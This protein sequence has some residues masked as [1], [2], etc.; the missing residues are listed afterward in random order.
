V[1][2][3]LLDPTNVADRENRRNRRK[4]NVK[5]GWIKS[6]YIVETIAE[7]PKTRETLGKVSNEIDEIVRMEM[8]K[9]VGE[10]RACSRKGAQFRDRCRERSWRL[11]LDQS[12]PTPERANR[13]TTRSMKEQESKII[14][15][16]S[17]ELGESRHMEHRPLNTSLVD[18]CSEIIDRDELGNG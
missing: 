13:G 6:K 16:D 12:T 14:K 7:G 9:K 10:D 8:S 1:I 15:G 4:G 5:E 3:E 11:I 18:Q 2:R 17:E